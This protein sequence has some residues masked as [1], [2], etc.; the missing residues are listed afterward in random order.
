MMMTEEGTRMAVP[1]VLHFL[2]ANCTWTLQYL[3]CVQTASI[4]AA[5][6]RAHFTAHYIVC[7]PDGQTLLLPLELFLP[8]SPIHPCACMAHYSHDLWEGRNRWTGS[9]VP[10]NWATSP[11]QG[12]S[13][14][15]VEQDLPPFP[16]LTLLT[17]LE[18]LRSEQTNVSKTPRQT[19][20]MI[21]RIILISHC[22]IFI[23]TL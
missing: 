9:W 23:L 4:P 6:L 19:V 3:V 12:S 7:K 1:S 21:S 16:A 11:P 10:R 20:D 22:I 14:C 15:R 2:G 8:A 17:L 18:T 5:T 13:L